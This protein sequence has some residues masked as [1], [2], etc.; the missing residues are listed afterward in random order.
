[1][2][3]VTPPLVV[4]EGDSFANDILDR[5]SYGE[6]LLNLVLRSNDALV[7]TCSDAV[8]GSANSVVLRIKSGSY[9]YLHQGDA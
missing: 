6:A 2:K 8:P 3:I 9:D 5:K 1:M 4:E 7:I